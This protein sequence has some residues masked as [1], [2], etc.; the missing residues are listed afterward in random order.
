MFKKLPR[1]SDF[2][3]LCY[4]PIP[5]SLEESSREKIVELVQ[6]F[7]GRINTIF[8]EVLRNFMKYFYT[9]IDNFEIQKI[10]RKIHNN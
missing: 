6:L 8:Y 4:P 7:S 9:S 5:F 2:Q 1:T 3:L 10:A